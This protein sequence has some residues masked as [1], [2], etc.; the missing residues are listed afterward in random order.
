[1]PIVEIIKE[2]C[3]NCNICV[4]VCPLDV[5]GEKNGTTPSIK[6]KEDCQSCYLCSTLC[7][8]GAIVITPDRARPTPLPY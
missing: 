3:K 5:L 8:E 4:E 1:M 6:Y 2:L 7:P